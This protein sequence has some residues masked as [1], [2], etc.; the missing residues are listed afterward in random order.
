MRV[1][2]A[3]SVRNW[4][5]A[6]LGAAA[7]LVGVLVVQR[8]DLV[9]FALEHLAG[10]AT[11]YKV[12]IG[13]QHLGFTHGAVMDVRVSRH[14]EPVL[15]AK[16]IDVYY[17]PRDLLPGSTHRFGITAI[18]IDAPNLTLIRHQ[19][20]S[21]NIAAA[22]GG[23]A[24]SPGR[25]DPIP[26]R[27]TARVRDGTATLIDRGDPAKADVQTAYGIHADLTLDTSA[28][29]HYALG[30]ALAASGKQPFSAVGTIDRTR[31]YAMHRL[32]A[33]AVPM[34]AIANTLIHSPSARVLQGEARA[35]DVRAY[36]FDVGPYAPIEYHVGGGLTIADG[37]LH[38]DVL[39]RPLQHIAG[40]IELV[41]DVVFS[42]DLS[43]RLGAVPVTVR[44]AIFNFSDPQ[45]RFG[46]SG[47]GDVASLREDFAFSK[48][49]P[50]RGSGTIGALIEGSVAEPIVVA[51]ATMKRAY[52]R[53]LPLDDTNVSIAI[54]LGHVFV[55]P[56][57][58]SYG[59]VTGSA[60]GV[61]TLGDTLRTQL[62]VHA[63]TDAAHVPYLD[64]LMSGEPIV[65]DA[66]FVGNGDV[67]GARGSLASLRGVQRMAAMFSFAP[68]GSTDIAPFW[69][70]AG[71]GTFA[72]R[73]VAQRKNDTSA[74][75]AA[76]SGLHL[77]APQQPV[78]PG[79][80]MPQ[81]PAIGGTLARGEVVGG[82]TSSRDV[83]LA[84][85][86]SVVGAT[87]AGVPFNDL[88]AVF[89]GNLA[90]A[91]IGMLH[92]DGSWGRFDGR[93]GFSTSRLTAI[94][95]YAGDLRGVTPLI[96]GIPA[97][98]HASGPIAIAFA[99]NR[100]VVQAR[101]LQFAPGARV[102]GVAMQHLTGTL[103]YEKGALR[104][105]SAQV[106]VAGGTLIAAGPLSGSGVAMVGT[107]MRGQDLAGLGLPI[108]GGNVAINGTVRDRGEPLPAFDGGVVVRGGHAA[109]YPVKGTAQLSLH[110]GSLEVRNAVAALGGAY[111][112][113]D[114]TVSGLTSG[115]PRY[116]L[117]AQVPAADV[118]S[119]LVTLR[120]P[121]EMTQGVFNG[122]LAIGGTGSAPSV[123]GP[124]EIPGGAVNG[125]PFTDGR[126]EIAAGTGAVA[127]H[128]GRVQVGS[129]AVRF[130]A[131]V[132][133]ASSA[134]GV[135]STRATLS[136]FDNFF[137]TGDTLDGVGSVSLVVAIDDKRGSTHGDVRVDG[138]RYRSLSFGDTLAH[139]SSRSNDVTGTLAIA[140]KHGSLHA[141]GTIG[142][143]PSHEWQRVLAKS[144]YNIIATIDDLD[145]STWLPA[146]GYPD[147][148]MLGKVDASARLRGAYPHLRV[149][150]IGSVADGS[151]ASLPIQTLSASV[152]SDGNALV[153]SNA[154][155]VA[156]GIIATANGTLGFHENSPLAL[157]VHASS[158]DLPMLVS[159]VAKKTID[160]H[161]TFE[162]TMKI[163]G[164]FGKP[165]FGGAF[166]ASNVTA[167]GV[168][169]A[170][171]FGSVRLRGEDIELSDAGLTFAQGSVTL[172]GT[173]PLQLRPFGIGPADSAMHFDLDVQGLDPGTFDAP[174]GVHTK[175]GGRI[176]GHLGL[177]GTVR[178][179]QIF[180]RI[181]ITKGS[182][183]SDLDR[184]P[185]TATVATMT[186]DRNRATI[187]SFNARFGSGDVSAKG[188]IAFEHGFGE[189]GDV[190]YA[191]HAV[192]T[193]AQA[194]LPAYGSG[195][196]D[197]F[198]DLTRTP[199]GLA[200][201][202]GK[203]TLTN[204][205]IPFGVFFAAGGSGG[206]DTGGGQPP[207]IGLKL[208]VAAA[209]N[210]R[211][212][213]GGVGAG[214]DIG[215]TGNALLAGTLRAPTLDGR[216]QS[217]GGT[218]TY[219]DRAFSMQ[220]GSVTF[221]PANGVMPNLRAVAVA[222][223]LN[224]GL[225][226]ASGN[227]DITISVSG[228]LSNMNV[229]LDSSPPGYS[230]EQLLALLAPFGS[231]VA[232]G[233][234]QPDIAA[235]PSLPGAPI[236]PTGALPPG[237]LVARGNGSVTVGQEAFSLLNAQF[238]SGLLAPLENAL[239]ATGLG[240]VDLSLDYY[241]GVGVN[242]RRGIGRFLNAIYSSSF[243][244]VQRQSFGIEY[245]PSDATA[246]QLSFFFESGPQRLL[247][248]S[249]I[250]ST[251]NY[252]ATA[253]QAINGQSGFSFTLQRLFW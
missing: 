224:P 161:G 147:V 207:N 71:N 32:R 87:V 167:Y 149:T 11:G 199:P 86:A 31:G 137:D 213:G 64:E 243:G 238:A 59:G 154:Q 210:V 196:L 14:G 247:E 108:D 112:Y 106:G 17:S 163:G 69:V 180:G 96:G 3:V 148:P 19:D 120:L 118:P 139:W 177:A 16:R 164:T 98:G 155:L 49:Q 211:I 214:L 55:S 113:V 117:R 204:A 95:D 15:A 35:V 240:S 231:L 216:F 81:L 249:P 42:N 45:F 225:Q 13:N 24:A 252:R 229:A 94:G 65:A 191:I 76:A 131:R 70:N 101:G 127:A 187:D 192:A 205:V 151:F 171:I 126:A 28:R 18:A 1:Y 58:A 189:L 174:L 152:S 219:F 62:L 92:A 130:F 12:R 109:S 103:A 235:A 44:G 73:Y 200:Q 156:P 51:H 75:W 198:V 52:Y 110:G 80:Q 48:D 197:G 188:T 183:A 93:G 226:G 160:V 121:T 228:P 34:S 206:S 25:P 153:V 234:G 140:G 246:A 57:T 125:L 133:P 182:Y 88:E 39:S 67:F 212:R 159:Q 63:V 102:H 253:G 53:D 10:F 89:A 100:I 29:T 8:H 194:D 56:M 66:L 40:R 248:S 178:A 146:I 83:V 2:P 138:L 41:D 116:A 165:T 43:A 241:G 185:V 134:F 27:L 54:A 217:T 158:N 175:L 179:P 97:S 208:A 104:V 136:D 237:V 176:D 30:G 21:Y 82:G 9:R 114:G 105:Y 90:D 218:L 129:T 170:S 26:L 150:G 36:A 7:V 193:G 79:L 145:L 141:N 111:A 68:D 128:H 239:G 60:R 4:L 22:S 5:L 142:L 250:F 220:S 38:I 186:F 230:R 168:Q 184:V 46:I 215:A 162:S 23:G 169:V 84:G 119:T 203:A 20:G 209:K 132:E 72:G 115:D 232:L 74:F 85:R 244:L 181:G 33:S 47:V 144:N 251:S 202:S 227:I 233:N 172:A 135:R 124:I 78:F 6:G 201:L 195:T 242:V 50:V 91:S 236:T 166:D 223:V 157:T 190:T 37:Q 99:D 245:A 221:D 143:S 107:G 122:V 173:L 77:T 61:L 222:H 123:T